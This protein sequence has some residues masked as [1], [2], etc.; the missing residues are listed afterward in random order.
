MLQLRSMFARVIT[1]VRDKICLYSSSAEVTI[2]IALVSGSCLG[3]IIV[4]MQ[5]LL[6]LVCTI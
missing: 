4:F 1:L 3:H 6:V 2:S 5:G